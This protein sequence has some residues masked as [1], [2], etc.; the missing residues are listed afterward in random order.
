MYVPSGI[1]LLADRSAGDL[2][3]AKVGVDMTVSIQGSPFYIAPEIM[4]QEL[5]GPYNTK[6]DVFRY[7]PPSDND[8][9]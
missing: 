7:R 4:A 8:F 6:V 5:L 2:G 9:V 1:C 3:V